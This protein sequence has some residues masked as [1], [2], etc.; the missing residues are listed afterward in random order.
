M[1]EG[2]K[3]YRRGEGYYIFAPAGGVATGW[4]TVLRSRSIWGPYEEKIVMAWAP[5]TINGPHQGGWVEA[6]DGSDWFLHFQDK[7]A[8]G[9]IVHLQPLTWREDGWPLIGEDP[10]GD[11]VGQPVSEGEVSAFVELP[12]TSAKG[13]Y[14]LG[15]EWQYPAVPSPYWHA[16]LA[17]GTLRLYAAQQP[18]QEN[19]WNCRNLLLQKFPAESFTV[20]ARLCFSP[21]P[22]LKEK[23]EEAGFIVM[24][25]DYALLRL[26]D[27][28][29]G[30]RLSYVTCRAAAKGT[31]EKVTE[32]GVLPYSEEKQ[33]YPYASGN[34]PPVIY[35]ARARRLLWVR[36]SVQPLAVEGNVTQA[37]CRFAYSTDGKRYKTVKETFVAQP[38]LWIGAKFG[39]Y[40]NRYSN[41]NDSGWLD[42]QQLQVQ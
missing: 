30:A 25:N 32:L 17:D 18:R 23:G 26:T 27:A 4:Q 21:N 9:R 13:P 38:E 14:G 20:E 15:L 1:R 35:P 28:E 34:V 39:F 5:G 6:P 22:Q 16:R 3:L 36:L 19:L 7:G 24:G 41:K 42:I 31:A 10:D 12:E 40:C 2:P 33:V 8:Y 37:L 29:E 11:G